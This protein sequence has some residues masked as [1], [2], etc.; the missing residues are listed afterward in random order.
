MTQLDS[1]TA[2]LGQHQFEVFKLDPMDSLA[3]LNI[4]KEAVAPALGAALG[5]IDSVDQLRDLLD[6]PDGGSKLG[7]SVEKL[8][9]SASL[10]RQRQVIDI[11][12]AKTHVGGKPLASQFD[13]IFRGDLPLM[14]DW[15]KLAFK[16]EWGNVGRALADGIGGALARTGSEPKSQ[17][18]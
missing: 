5:A 14:F 3:A 8:L 4:V 9:M 2:T 16:G 10:E 7:S 12:K 15:L 6:A 11:F 1:T 13:L 17:A 18:T